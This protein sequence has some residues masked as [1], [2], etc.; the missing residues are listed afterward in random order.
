MASG[1]A[2]ASMVSF[3][4]RATPEED[5]PGGCDE[6]FLL[7]WRTGYGNRRLLRSHRG[8]RLPEAGVGVD[9]GL[10]GNTH[11]RLDFEQVI[12][13]GD[14]NISGTSHQLLV[15]GLRHP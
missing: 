3:Y 8:F 6:L 5:A 13:H 2:I 4:C 15:R 12:F 10:R 9:H 14:E 7:L 1:V 11:R